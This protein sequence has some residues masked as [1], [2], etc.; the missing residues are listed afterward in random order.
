MS[1]MNGFRSE[2]I[3]KI[4]GFNSHVIVHS[5]GKVSEDIFGNE[6]DALLDSYLETNSGEVV[7]IKEKSL[8]KVFYKRI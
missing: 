3:N 8:Q 4:V 5:Y 7:L 1:V 6:V 2:L